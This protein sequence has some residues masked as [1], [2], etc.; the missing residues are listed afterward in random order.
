MITAKAAGTVE[1]KK[2]DILTIDTPWVTTKPTVIPPFGCK[3]VK[4]LVGPLPACS[5]WVN[6][7][8]EPIESHYIKQGVM[9]TST[10][11]NFHPGSRWVGMILRN[12][13]AQEVRIPPKTV[14][15][16]VQASDIVPNTKA[17]RYTS[18]VFPLTEQTEL[19][20]CQLSYL[21][22][23]NLCCWSWVIQLWRYKIGLFVVGWYM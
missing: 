12:L 19:S 2:D 14:I 8:V 1:M 7:I 6:V 15:S 16:N 17:P 18:E 11:Q 21:L 10:Y 9:V 13:S 4:G 22:F 23:Y 3:W 5:Y 20:W